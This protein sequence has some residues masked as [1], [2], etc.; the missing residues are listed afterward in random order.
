M[1]VLE[2]K[3]SRQIIDELCSLGLD[4]FVSLPQI[5]AMGDTSSGKSSVL[6][7]LS[8][9]SFPSA[10]KLCTRCPTTLM[11]TRSPKFECTVYLQRYKNP[12]DRGT[13]VEVSTIEEITAEIEKLTNQLVEE[14]QSISDDSIIIK[15]KGPTMPDFTLT[16]LPGIVRTVVDGEDD[17]MI[18]RIRDLIHR[19][20]TQERTIILA[21]H[22]AD[23]DIH[24]SEVL[25]AA[26][27]ADPE[28]VRT[29]CVISKPDKV[30][31]ENESV[32]ELL[33]GKKFKLELGFHTIMCR[34]P[35]A[36]KNKKTIEDG[37]RNETNFFETSPAWKGVDPSCFGT[38]QLK[39]KLVELLEITVA[40][41]LPNVIEEINTKLE[42]CKK[43]LVKLGEPM[44]TSYARRS[45]YNSCI[46]QYLTL[47]R[48]ATVGDYESSFFQDAQNKFITH[49]CDWNDSFADDM[50]TKNYIEKYS[51]IVSEFTEEGE[52]VWLETRDEPDSEDWYPEM[53]YWQNSD[54]IK[55]SMHLLDVAKLNSDSHTYYRWPRK[56][57]L[58]NIKQTIK[59]RR[60]GELRIFPSYNVF[61]S[62]FREHSKDW[63]IVSDSLA[64]K[65]FDSYGQVST[66]AID[67][68]S[69]GKLKRFL[70]DTTSK[71]LR[72]TM[73]ECRP[74]L[75]HLCK[76]ENTPSTLNHYLEDTLMKLRNGSLLEKIQNLK[77]VSKEVVIQIIK[78]EGI[79]CMSPADREAQEMQ[80][81]LMAYTKVA[82]KRFTDAV[83]MTIRHYFFE[84][85]LGEIAPRLRS[86]NDEILEDLLAENGFII[87]ARKAKTE[88]LHALERSRI[89]IASMQ[90]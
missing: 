8:G 43:E 57:D 20:M 81:A 76:L 1:T 39:I 52:S 6:S 69:N 88:E 35:K 61:V 33:S 75:D 7:A 78:S 82:L 73:D 3:R 21:V 10:E 74:P 59:E 13:I 90:S 34:S 85:F 64:S 86:V 45:F 89:L 14:G 15:C 67:Y 25:N 46:E 83:P 30:G 60:T 68:V 80:W 28:G 26:K 5:V 11:L 53:A 62:L 55:G 51:K 58:S 79:G 65:Y 23:V 19:Y 70:K 27:Q 32:L 31:E 56:P 50:R 42:L 16:D 77:E 38:N 22:P 71:V 37:I 40:N 24:N 4:K 63:K 47:M 9:I 72:S 12:E 29:I 48:S 84:K 49:V 18:Q 36:L 66:N 44:D 41:A 2:S 54:K 17:S 87:K